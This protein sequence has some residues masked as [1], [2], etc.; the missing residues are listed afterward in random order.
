MG[1]L[2]TLSAVGGGD[3]IHEHEGVWPCLR[4]CRMCRNTR[5]LPLKAAMK[6]SASS[7]PAIPESACNSCL[8]SLILLNVLVTKG[9][10]L[11]KKFFIYNLIMNLTIYPN[12]TQHKT[13][14]ASIKAASLNT[15]KNLDLLGL[16]CKSNLAF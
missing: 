4:C 7:D 10:E 5:S 13:T 12:L 9:S 2:L 16:K 14:I 11:I 3:T 8:E 1:M 6:I 15:F